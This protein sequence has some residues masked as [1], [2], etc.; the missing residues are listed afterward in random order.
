MNIIVPA[1]VNVKE[2]VGNLNLSPTRTKSIKNKIY[3]FLSLVL[4]TNHNAAL[5]EK[6][7]GYRR[8]SSVQMKK[9]MG[10]KDYHLIIQLLTNPQRPV[11]ESNKSWH[12]GKQGGEGYCQGY[13][14]CPEFNTGEVLWKT[15]PS[16]FQ[17]RIEKHQKKKNRDNFD[18]SKYA[19]LYNQFKINKLSFDPSVNEYIDAFGKELLSRAKGNE[20]QTN[21]VLN[22]IGRWLY[23][24]EKIENDNIWR[25]VSPSNWRLN[26]TITHLKRTLRPFLL[27][28]GQRLG[29]VDV[30]A[31][32]PYILT[33][34][35]KDEFI[36][37]NDGI[38]NLQT[39]SP[40]VFHKLLE[41]G[42]ITSY[43]CDNTYSFGYTSYS[44]TTMHTEFNLDLGSSTGDNKKTISFM[45]GSFY[46]EMEME[47]IKSYQQAPF[48]KDFYRYLVGFIKSKAE[49]NTQDEDVLRERMK[50]NMRLELFDD[51]KKHR[52]N[53]HYLKMFKE[54]Y[55]GVDK[56]IYALLKIIGKTDFSY[57]L[58]RA[59]S[60]IVLDLISRDFHEKHPSAPIFTIHDAICTYPD[61]IPTLVDIT[62]RHFMDIIGTQV[63][64]KIKTWQ[65]EP[66]P[67]AKDINEEW[68]EIKPVVTLQDYKKIAH[69]IIPSNI[70]RANHFLSQKR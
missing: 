15:I 61:Y 18:D 24:I 29:E 9:I 33:S 41:A 27:C 23:Y 8:I 58:Q 66:L 65:P 50:K 43:S 57:L 48:S 30:N 62:N 38:F 67:R 1:S 35:M 14:L 64:L 26:S 45:W 55:P 49:I 17:R 25:N 5:N 19:F 22:R 4:Q 3:Y 39:I 31:S 12:N 63:G 21:M 13:R 37:G 42:Y 6:S 40:R 2:L 59:E 54:L 68:I 44:G 52:E 10:R 32:H 69:K 34:V 11:I 28:N 36:T 16:K 20:F 51:N 60:Y 70:E 46:N 56:W 7:A 53:G 47:S